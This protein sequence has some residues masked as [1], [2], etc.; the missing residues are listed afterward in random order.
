LARVLQL[1]D[2]GSALG[3]V[4][5]F[6]GSTSLGI[7]SNQVAGVTVAN[8]SSSFPASARALGGVLVGGEHGNTSGVRKHGIKVKE[9]ALNGWLTGGSKDGSGEGCGGGVDVPVVLSGLGSTA[10]P[11][12]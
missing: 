4:V 3:T 9:V 1:V 6:G 12:W 7:L 5:I 8:S 2:G 11:A 10:R